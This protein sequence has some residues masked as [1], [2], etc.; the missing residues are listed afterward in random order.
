V[1]GA[2]TG[3]SAAAGNGQAII[4][5]TAP[6]NNGGAPITSYTVTSSGGQA[7]SG[8]SSPVT[9]TGL[10]NGTAYTFT[11]T[12]TNSAGTGAASS[13][14][15]S[16]TPTLP[17]TSISILSGWNL[18]GNG[19]ANSLS[20][21]TLFPNASQVTS[22]WKWNSAKSEWAFYSPSLSSAALSSYASNQGYEVLSTINPGDGFWINAA[23]AFTLQMPTGTPILASSYQ[24]NASLAL[25]HGWSLISI[26][27]SKSASGF[28]SA[29][30]LNPP[31]AGSIPNNV[32]SLWTWDANHSEWY[33]YAPSLDST[34]QLKSY[35]SNQGYEDFT[36]SG[37]TLGPGVGFWVN[38]P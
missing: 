12:A 10:T 30:S 38:A 6:S 17:A 11:V 4:T 22:V 36:S 31:S 18:V 3:V 19:F 13:P 8:S 37:M 35:I 2:P 26:G 16:V 29:L 28:N 32:V 1:P 20:L 34:G 25:P 15:N 14:S 24:P 23:T 5:F 7:A 21:T 27:E 33:F 9:V